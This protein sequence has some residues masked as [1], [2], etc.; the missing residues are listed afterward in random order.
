MA[1]RYVLNVFTG[2]LDLIDVVDTSQF[3]QAIPLVMHDGDVWA[4]GEEKQGI[5]I[6][7][8]DMTDGGE[9]SIGEDGEI[10]QGVAA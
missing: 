10:V 2:N 3:A 8:I 9:I 6:S 1:L 7:E 4:I 5:Y